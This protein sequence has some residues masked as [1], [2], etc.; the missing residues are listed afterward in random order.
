MK[1]LRL[2]ILSLVLLNLPSISL[3]IG[4]GAFSSILS[5]AS[6]GLLIA[7][8]ILS[9]KSR[10]NA[11]MILLGLFFFSVSTLSGQDFVPSEIKYYYIYIVK[12]FIYIICGYELLKKVSANEM[13]IF[14][15]IGTTTILMETLFLES[16]M[17]GSGRLSGIYINPNK[18]GF[19]CAAA[20]AM[21]Y[22]VPK[23]K[24]RLIIQI[25][26]TL[27]G[28]LTFSR[29]F[30]VIWVLLNLI[31]LMI[32]FKNIRIFLY[33]MG[34][35][36]CLIILGELLSVQTARLNEINS[37]LSGQ[38]SKAQNLTTGLRTETWALYYN[39]ISNNLLFGNGFSAFGGD[40]E[41]NEVGVHNSY[42]KV[43]GEAGI[44]VFIFFTAMFISLLLNTYKYF[45]TMPH[46]FLGAVC[47]SLYIT[48]THNF[49]DLGYLLFI[50]MWIQA[51][52]EIMN[53]KNSNISVDHY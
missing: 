32:D 42:L 2:I 7:Y 53:N 37:L 19:V 36:F 14:L 17:S 24:L 46:L 44:F 49:F 38:D 15:F 33:G 8:Y 34:L 51:R 9:T 31:S 48:T 27:M 1:I 5:L 3:K 45:K 40:T 29:T 22:S 18:A 21:A 12:Y 16:V 35:V 23:K 25:I 10:L 20:Y 50:T 4:S 6:F 43:L 52:V 47:L 28:L 41:I 30:M 11:W 26:V 13:L 39:A